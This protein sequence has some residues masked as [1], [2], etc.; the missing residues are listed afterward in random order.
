MFKQTHD[1]KFK[2]KWFIRHLK[3][4]AHLKEK[5]VEWTHCSMLGNRNPQVTGNC[6]LAMSTDY[7]NFFR[8]YH[9]CWKL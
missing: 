6:D 7:A 5:E 8:R 4:N 1:N 3:E 9:W 2:A